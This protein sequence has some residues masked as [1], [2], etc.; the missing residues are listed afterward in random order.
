M[1]KEYQRGTGDFLAQCLF[2]ICLGGLAGVLWACQHRIKALLGH[3]TPAAA[4]PAS[5]QQPEP[6]ATK[7]SK[8]D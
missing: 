3:S 8:T 1:A 4:S 7:A 2:A 6:V 5:P